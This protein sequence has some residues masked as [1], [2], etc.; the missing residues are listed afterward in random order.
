[1]RKQSYDVFKGLVQFHTI[2]RLQSQIL[3]WDIVAP[4]VWILK[5]S[6]QIDLLI[7]NGELG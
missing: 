3:N 5:S 1:M 4:R 2:C 7:E 6:E